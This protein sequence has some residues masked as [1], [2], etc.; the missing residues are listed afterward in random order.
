MKKSIETRVSRVLT[1][2]G[3]V[4][5]SACGTAVPEDESWSESQQEIINGTVPSPGGLASFGVVSL[6]GCTGTLLTNRHVLTAHHCVRSDANAWSG[7]LNTGIIATFEDGGTS[8]TSGVAQIFEPDQS[9]TL[10]AHD[11]AL[12]TLTTPIKVTPGDSTGFSNT[13]Y[14]GTDA[15]LANQFVFCAGYGGTTAATSTSFASGFGTLTSATIKI[16][17][18]SSGTL[19]RP[20]NTSNQVG[21]GGDSGSTCFL[22]GSVVGVQST[23]GGFSNFDLNGNGTP[24]ESWAERGAPSSCTD[25]APSQFRAW[26]GQKVQVA[27]NVNFVFTAAMTGVIG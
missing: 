9:W 11:Y 26:A 23:C 1:I 27:V 18:T 10:N 16:T 6:G 15:S 12:L 13:I 2:L 5:L 19:T 21:F 25:A 3:A 24:G 8:Q 14:T 7:P 17:G 22:S 20:T 4:F